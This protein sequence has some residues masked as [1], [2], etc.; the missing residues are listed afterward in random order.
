MK[1]NLGLCDARASCN[2]NGMKKYVG[3]IYGALGSG[4]YIGVPKLGDPSCGP[5]T[6]RNYRI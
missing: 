4:V 5:H 1:W 2:S 6:N 3:I